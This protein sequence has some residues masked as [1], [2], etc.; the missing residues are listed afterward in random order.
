VL[1]ANRVISAKDRNE[2]VF[3]GVELTKTV[4]N[5]WLMFMVSS[6]KSEYTRLSY[7]NASFMPRERG[8]A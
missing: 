4:C 2:F 5:V 1:L 8:R 3:V 7:K 6:S